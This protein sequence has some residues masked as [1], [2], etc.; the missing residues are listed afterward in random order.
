MKKLFTVLVVFGLVTGF[1]GCLKG[2]DTSCNDKSPA[3]EEAA[4]LAYAS[5]NGITG[6]LDANGIYYQI[7]TAGNSTRPTVNSTVVVHYE[8]RLCSTNA[9]FDQ[10]TTNPYTNVLGNLIAAWQLS[11]PNIGEG[12]V[13]RIICPSTL[14]YGCSGAGNGVIPGN[15]I[16]YFEIE[17]V[18]VQ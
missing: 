10:T 12:G 4:I 8:G 1:S 13:M 16:L 17:L 6:T 11:L 7:V 9:I 3:S 5:T 15:S 18:D 2:K 14:A